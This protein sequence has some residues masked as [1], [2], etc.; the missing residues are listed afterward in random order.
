MRRDRAYWQRIYL[1]LAHAWTQARG[2]DKQRL[3]DACR[4][5]YRIYRRST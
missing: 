4:T 5:A 1:R 3:D 2:D